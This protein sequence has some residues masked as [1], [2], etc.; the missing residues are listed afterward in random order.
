ML[1]QYPIFLIVW[2]AIVTSGVFSELR[3]E[4]LRIELLLR[5]SSQT[6]KTAAKLVVSAVGYFFLFTAVYLVL[7]GLLEL[8]YT[9]SF[10]SPG[11]PELS[12]PRVVWDAFLN[13]LL[14]H[15]WF[16]LGAVYFRT[17]NAIKT[18]L[19]IAAVGLSYSLVAAAAGRLIFH[20]YIIGDRPVV[21]QEQLSWNWKGYQWIGRGFMTLSV[22]F[23]RALSRQRLKETEA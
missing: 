12:A 18:L 19:V 22:P 2:G 8:I 14:V 1:E 16:F 7:N 6:E 23:F 3:D 9:L 17:H 10:G 13:Y 4:A 5:P 21:L 15:S 20:P 11:R